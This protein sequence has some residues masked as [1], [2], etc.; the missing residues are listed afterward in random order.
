MREV[1]SFVSRK[2]RRVVVRALNIPTYDP[3]TEKVVSQSTQMYDPSHEMVVPHGQAIYDPNVFGRY[4]LASQRVV[5][6]ADVSALP[7][8][9]D[10]DLL[11]A[12]AQRHVSTGATKLRVDRY[13][14]VLSLL[15]PGSG[16]CLDACTNQPRNDV[17]GAVTELGYDYTPIDITG[18]DVDV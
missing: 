3:K 5:P 1:L 10:F 18:D 7:N 17:R 9:A 11:M 6:K 15:E 13:S 14:L 4:D 16:I 12:E 2:L 8:E